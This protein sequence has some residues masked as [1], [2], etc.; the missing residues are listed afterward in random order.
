MEVLA[1]FEAFLSSWLS[2]TLNAS[3]D[4]PKKL[5][6]SSSGSLGFLFTLLRLPAGTLVTQTRADSQS[7]D[8][9]VLWSTKQRRVKKITTTFFPPP[10]PVGKWRKKVSI[11][12]GK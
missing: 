9:R 8:E 11:E 10:L 2:S 3:G 12:E 6:L 1:A 5:T 7:I 4:I